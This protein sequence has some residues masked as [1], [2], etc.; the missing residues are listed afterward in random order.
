VHVSSGDTVYVLGGNTAILRAAGGSLTGNI[1]FSGN[2][3]PDDYT[4][5]QNYPNPFNPVTKIQFALPKAGNISL[6]VYDVT[7]RLV[8]SLI[9]NLDMNAGTVKIDFDGSNFASGV[10]FY[11]LI[12]DNKLIATKKMIL[13]K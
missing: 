7:G 4:L 13:T 6:N 3:I 2:I 8:S 11:S 12:A 1:N 9:D 10:Y 5:G